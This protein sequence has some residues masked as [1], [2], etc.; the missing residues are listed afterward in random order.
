M[1]LNR[2]RAYRAAILHFTDRPDPRA[3]TGYQYFEDGVLLVD[4]QGRVQDL[5]TAEAM[6][7]QGMDL[8]ECEHFPDHLILPGLIDSHIHSPQTEVIASYGEQL[9]DWLNHY[10]FPAEAQYADEHYARDGA[11]QFLDLLLAHG[12]TTA[13][14]YTS[15]F[16]QSTEAFFQAAERRN[17]RMIAGKVM[18]DRNAPAVL[19]DTVAT[20][21]REC[22][23]LIETWHGR[24]RLHY[25]LTPRFAPTS[26]PEQLQLAGKLLREYPGLYLQTHLSENH[27]EVAWVR[28]LFPRARDYLDVY[29]RAGLLGPRSVFG[30]GLHLSDRELRRLAQSGS[31][32]AFCPTSN[33]FLGSGLL[34]VQLLGDFGVPV[35]IA[36]D[37]G[38][39]TSF[40]MLRTLSEAYKVLQLQRQKLHP[41]L[42]FYWITLGNARRLQL[43]GVIG[44]FARGKEADFVM[45]DLGATPLQAARQSKTHSLTEILFALMMLGDE[46]NV[47]RTYVM[48]Q[49]MFD[50]RKGAL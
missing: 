12:T 44:N 23:A 13:M 42:A 10:T 21:E 6:Q 33:L 15:V 8:A 3:G 37:V 41:L 49:L 48:G 18:M 20:G 27:Q 34:D 47:A 46:Q 36:T 35:A 25:A 9:I 16:A 40:S 38:G 29:D 4:E 24:H 26:T 19:T 5:D 39:G 2:A 17:L 43:D 28:E 14:V 22:R 31:S 1:S 7:S 45:M 30:H 50:R 32:I 11:E